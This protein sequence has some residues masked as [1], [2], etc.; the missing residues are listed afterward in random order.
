MRYKAIIQLTS[1]EDGVIRSVASQIDNL[2][3][4]L[5]S[6]VDIELVCHGQSLP[7]V[8]NEGNRWGDVIMDMLMNHI[9]IIACENMLKTNSK[10][11]KDLFPGI[12]TVPAAIAEIVVKQQEGWS[13]I[14]AGF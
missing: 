4:A 2:V 3:K 9:E 8:L 5:N 7:F 12:K 13:Y 6:E 11:A 1:G 14:K 10:T